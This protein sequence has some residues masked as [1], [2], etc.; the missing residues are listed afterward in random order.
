M[1]ARLIR[2][3]RDY[4]AAVRLAVSLMS[5]SGI[6]RP[7]SN[8][9]WTGL[10]IPQSGELR[11]GIRYYKHGYGCAVQLPC[12]AVDFDFGQNGEID[13]FDAW[14]LMGFAALRDCDYGFSGES[15][16]KDVFEKA[17]TS[18][19]LRFSGYLLYYVAV[20]SIP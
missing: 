10:D 14:R 3:I 13:G 9:D 11:D 5:G 15:E 18:S 4:Q 20:P 7:A 19:D 17:V 12:G 16:L 1:D 6:G 2:L 8:I